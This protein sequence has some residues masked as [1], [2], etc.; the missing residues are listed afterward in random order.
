M[1]NKTAA[2]ERQT[3]ENAALGI[4]TREAFAAYEAMP[5]DWPVDITRLRES[6]CAQLVAQTGISGER[7]RRAI[8]RAIRRRRGGA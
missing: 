2:A 7:A 4:V 5:R 3:V 8:T 1:S 6:W